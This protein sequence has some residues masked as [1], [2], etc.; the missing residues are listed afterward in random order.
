[1][2]E[3]AGCV[4]PTLRAAWLIEPERMTSRKVVSWRRERCILL[5]NLN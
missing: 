5:H 2:V 4:R 3:T 1:M